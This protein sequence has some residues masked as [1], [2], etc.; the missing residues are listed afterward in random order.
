MGYRA[1]AYGRLMFD[2]V[3]SIPSSVSPVVSIDLSITAEVLTPTIVTNHVLDMTVAVGR[4]RQRP[5]YFGYGHL[6][7]PCR[8][9]RGYL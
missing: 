4:G 6:M 2:P 7:D 1:I 3:S 5:W 8:H 9:L